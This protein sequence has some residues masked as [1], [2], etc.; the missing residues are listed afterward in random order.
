MEDLIWVL[1]G[2]FTAFLCSKLMFLFYCILQV[3]CSFLQVYQEKVYDLINTRFIVDLAVREHPKK[4]TKKTYISTD[5]Q[6]NI[7]SQTSKAFCDLCP[8]N[9]PTFVWVFY[10]PLDV[11]YGQ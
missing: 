3:T 5:T 2:D 4:G 1:A 7:Y 8:D 11:I 6:Y 9:F 10:F